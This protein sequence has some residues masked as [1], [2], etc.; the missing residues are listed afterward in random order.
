MFIESIFRYP[1]K[2]VGSEDLVS[3]F[4]KTNKTLPWDRY[5]G[6]THEKSFIKK[7]SKS[8]LNPNTFSRCY[9]FKAFSAISNKFDENSGQM[10]LKHPN[11]TDFKFNIFKENDFSKLIYWLQN[12]CIENF[13]KP[14]D[15]FRS[16]K[17]GFTDTSYP[18]ISLNF[19]SSLNSLT[20]YSGFPVSK[21][22][23]R[24]NI[25]ISD[26]L[27]W[28]ELNMINKKIKIGKSCIA[29][30]RAYCKMQNYRI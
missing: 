30:Y 12:L 21:G 18:S 6:I 25:W 11:L 17:F 13:P 20:E 14:V 2:S 10:L 4:L 1:I 24:A 5:W 7:N 16:K 8:W 27:P 19:I 26:S 29:N 15:L 23:F 9:N 28:Q 3:V 22:R